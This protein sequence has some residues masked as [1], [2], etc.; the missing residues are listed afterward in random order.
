MKNIVKLL[1]LAVVC[2]LLLQCFA[3]APIM[4]AATVANGTAFEV[5]S[6]AN[7][8][9]AVLLNIYDNANTYYYFDPSDG[10]ANHSVGIL[11]RVADP[12]G[13]AE[14]VTKMDLAKLF[15]VANAQ[16]QI[17]A[18][19]TTIGANAFWFDTDVYTSSIDVYF[20][21]IA[22]ATKDSSQVVLTLNNKDTSSGG[23]IQTL[24]AVSGITTSEGVTTLTATDTDYV[25]SQNKW[26]T[27]TL[28]YDAAKCH[29]TLYINEKG[30]SAEP[31]EIV[32]RDLAVNLGAEPATIKQ[33]AAIV[34]TFNS[35]AIIDA[36]VNPVAYL[37]NV[38]L[39]E[40]VEF[41]ADSLYAAQNES[42]VS[43]NVYINPYVVS[44]ASVTYNGETNAIALNNSEFYKITLPVASTDAGKKEYTLT[45]TAGDNTYSVKRAIYIGTP[46]ASTD[47]TYTSFVDF[48]TG[49]TANNVESTYADYVADT[50]KTT[51]TKT[52]YASSNFRNS[53]GIIT[54]ASMNSTAPYVEVVNKVE[55]DETDKVLKLTLDRNDNLS[56]SGAFG[57]H[58]AKD[59]FAIQIGGYNNGTTNVVP[60]GYK[61]VEFDVKFEGNIGLKMYRN[62]TKSKYTG[63][64]YFLNSATGAMLN[65]TKLSENTWHHFDVYVDIK[66]Q[67]AD[68]YCDGAYVGKQNMYINDTTN[69]NDLVNWFMIWIEQPAGVA[70][71]VHGDDPAVA[72]CYIDNVGF[73]DLTNAHIAP[74]FTPANVTSSKD[75]VQSGA[76]FTFTSNEAYLNV[77]EANL[78]KIKAYDVKGNEIPG[79]VTAATPAQT[80]YV[81]D[82]T[83]FTFTPAAAVAPHKTVRINIPA[84]FALYADAAGTTSTTLGV[85]EDMYY[86]VADGTFFFGEPKVT[87]A[88]DKMSAT[89]ESTII[90]WAT[91]ATYTYYIA[92]YNAA[93]ELVGVKAIKK[94]YSL[95]NPTVTFKEAASEV[96]VL[97]WTGSELIPFRAET[98]VAA[99]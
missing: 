18:D 82:T 4:A 99:N 21:N 45:Y 88:A 92:G 76:A 42:T 35:K 5:G 51:Y 16:F 89:A 8:D 98:T 41:D 91:D 17:D 86:N 74:K 71:S 40:A 23:W 94:G 75:Y 46:A 55:N 48:N 34:P 84:D 50:E 80:T 7:S 81:L 68:V 52:M 30:S 10:N 11:S 6:T 97:V 70:N 27:F 38:K 47:T 22:M 61:R 69:G 1:S 39:R 3:I 63:G 85:A 57:T 66:K 26:Y 72:V 15:G 25:I 67:H 62:T 31:V 65:G 54:G 60:T 58:T 37:N 79:T 2:C 93:G 53:N 59:H 28:V 87:I 43:D 73:T 24:N 90:G 19:L 77:T 64:D 56:N 9:E 33:L 13:S 95:I 29:V 78:A 20:E 83:T 32:S 96:K 44:A 36:T 12:A 49:I 14:Y